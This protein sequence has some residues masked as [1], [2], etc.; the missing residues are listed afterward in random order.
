MPSSRCTTCSGSKGAGGVCVQTALN[1][2][3]EYNVLKG[4]R[5]PL[6]KTLRCSAHGAPPVVFRVLG[7]C[8][9]AGYGRV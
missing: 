3:A 1:I 8:Q 7:V 9:S 2:E 4:C 5:S 6:C